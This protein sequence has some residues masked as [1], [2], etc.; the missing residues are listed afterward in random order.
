MGKLEFERIKEMVVCLDG[1]GGM[2]EESITLLGRSTH[3]GSRKNKERDG[4]WEQ[5]KNKKSRDRSWGDHPRE[6]KEKKKERRE[7]V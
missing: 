3:V 7:Q 1:D 2:I 6:V 5:E 4:K